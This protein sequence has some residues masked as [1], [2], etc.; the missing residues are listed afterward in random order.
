MPGMKYHHQEIEPRWQRTWAE[1]KVFS[2]SDH[3]GREKKYI[4]DM[5]PYPSGDGLHVG[6]PE[7]YTATDIISR[8]WRMNSI[9]V[10]HPMGWDAFGL[11]AENAAIKK[12]T[13]PQTVTDQNIKN[14]KRQ[15]Q[16]IGFSYD[17]DREINTTDPKYYRWTQWIFLQLFKK[18]LAYEKEA[19]IWWCPKDKTGLANEEVVN[20]KCDRCGTAVEKKMLKQWMLKITAYAE[21]L[22]A[23]LDQLDWPEGIKTLQRNWIGKSEGAEVIFEIENKTL[24]QVQNDR[25]LVTVFTTRPDTL[26]GATYLVLSPEHELVKDITADKQKRAVTKY[27]KEIAGKSDLERTALEKEKTGVFTGA[28]AINPAN[29]EKIPVWIADYVLANYGTGAI[30]A[31]SAHD[32]RDLAFAKK[33]DL[34]IRYVVAPHLVDPKNPPRL[35]KPIRERLTVQAIIHDPKTDQYLCLKWKEQPWTTFIVGG[36]EPGEDMIQAAT[37]EIIEETGYQQVS[38]VKQ[39]GGPVQA[40]YFAAHKNENRVAL[41]T[42]LLFELKGQR[43]VEVA[44]EEQ[45]K[46]EVV[47]Q[48]LSAITPESLNCVELPFWL[49]QL[50]ADTAYTGEGTMINSGVFN[51]WSSAA[52]REGIIQDL[53]KQG[54]AKFSVNYKLRDW[55]FS[56]QRYW[57]E[58]IPLV[59]C[60]HCVATVEST[61]HYLN[62]S[63]RAIWQNLLDGKKTIETR[64][65][66][67]DE[68]ARYFGQIKAGDYIKGIFTPTGEVAYFRVKNI[69]K[70]ASAQELFDDK[71]TLS[72]VA[73]TTTFARAAELE[74]AYEK[75]SP[76]YA[77]KIAQNG[78]VALT[79]RHVLPGI[80]LD[81]E[82]Q[83]PILLPQVEKYEPTGTGESPLA[84]IDDWVNVTCRVCGHPAKRETNTMPQWAG[85][86]WYYLRFCD[87]HNDQEFASAE[88]MKS[89][90]PVDLYVGG[91]EHAVLHLLYSR[92]WHMVLFDLGLIPKENNDG[93]SLAEPFTKLKNQGL[94]LGPDGEKMSK[95]R[96]NVISPD[97]IIEKYGADTLRM[98]EMF[99]GPFEDAK[100][101]DINGI[102][103]V[104]RFLD[105]VW[106]ARERLNNAAPSD[107]WHKYVLSITVGINEFRFNTCVS[108]LMK[109][110][111]DFGTVEVSTEEYKIFLHILSPF[112]PHLAEEVWSD[113]GH[114]SLLSQEKWPDYD[115]KKVIEKNVTIAVQVMGKLRGTV[116]VTRG[117]DQTTVE[118]LAKGEPNVKKF[119]LGQPKKV[120]FVP[121]K[122][123]NFVV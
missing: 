4:L 32:D 76:G 118:T 102:L 114:D 56:R 96:G 37:R 92:F 65:L 111:N 110:V 86:C 83:L 45:V 53:E 43:R 89:W 63:S 6:H 88:S 103:G 59:H 51:G 16:S 18:G 104:R 1:K 58:P 21:R 50:T 119:L 17:W 24:K 26:F 69:K 72:A 44:T 13:H 10:L 90:L 25:L 2:V 109:W 22:L 60:Q 35:G 78:L 29:H 38:F 112:A 33:Y 15:I 27:L 31:V 5:F 64:A 82:E 74:A 48:P 67:P 54:R 52:G 91:A 77:Q 94:I 46:H 100:P 70:F 36:V 97:E 106:R 71:V 79:V 3:A 81:K 107:R 93:V 8:Y 98:Y 42:A 20:G 11:P 95:S 123:I 57:G 40:E 87:P 113:L 61:P 73:P 28:Y 115:P 66:N 84:A 62:F 68:P 12:K 55:I 47:W 120:I 30:M 75:M 80:I 41:A 9:Q 14:F 23:G 122:L 105:K 85:S 117:S 39:L 19:P 7:G 116:S 121:D 34:P 108:D 101:W 49:S 99:M